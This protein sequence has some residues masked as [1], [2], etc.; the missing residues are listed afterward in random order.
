MSKDLP[1]T[2]LPRTAERTNTGPAYHQPGPR[3]QLF[4]NACGYFPHI[5]SKMLGQWSPLP[6][7]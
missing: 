7:H 6:W 1:K 2:V 3:Y 4:G 5:R